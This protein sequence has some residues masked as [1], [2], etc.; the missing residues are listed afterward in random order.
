LR[1]IASQV[2]YCYTCPITML[3]KFE[4]NDTTALYHQIAS[5]VRRAIREGEVSEGDRLPATRDLATSLGVNMHTVVRAYGIL[6]DEGLLE[7]RRG[8]GA[9]VTA[10]GTAAAGVTHLVKELAAE[11]HRQGFELGELTDMITKE[12]S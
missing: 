1:S 10:G 9:T 11:A 4:P 2:P 7:M 6:R 5:A 8:R 12:F 3:I